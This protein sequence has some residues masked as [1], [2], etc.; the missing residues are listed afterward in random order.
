MPAF[1]FR[2]RISPLE[3]LCLFIGAVCFVAVNYALGH[4]AASVGLVMATVGTGVSTDTDFAKRQQTFFNPKILHALQNSLKLAQ[5]GLSEGYKTI[6]NT[7]RFFRP[8]K[9]NVSGINAAAL[10]GLNV[11]PL[12]TPT[13]LT[14][15]VKPT[16]LT[17]VEIGYVDI[18]MTQRAALSQITDIVTALDLFNTLM[19]FSKTMGEDAALDYDT[20]IRN[21]LISAVYNSNNTYNNGTDGGFFERFAGVQNTGVSNDDFATLA[22]LSKQNGR[23]T[24]GEALK[25]VTQL[26]TAK[27]QPFNG[28]FVC[29][30][31]PQV[32]HDIRQDEQWLRAATFKGDPLYKDLEIMLDGVAYVRATNPWMEGAVYG[33]ESATD[34]GDGLIYSSIYLGQEAFGIPNLSNKNAGGSQSAPKLTIVDTPDKSDPLN[35]LR[36]VGW[37]SFF[38]AGAFIATS[39]G[40]TPITGERPRELVLRTKSTFS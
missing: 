5:Y 28:N 37:K 18:V 19:V 21:W 8:R 10:T 22:G 24:R 15:G 38:G 33:T 3:L 30:C 34:P 36:Y 12:T 31:P 11:T 6:G 23:I 25:C 20:V 26:V 29:V 27:V 9:A 35:Q 16:N 32:V 2:G 40:T 7:V 4:W 13:V 1:K 14:E 39:N 17:A